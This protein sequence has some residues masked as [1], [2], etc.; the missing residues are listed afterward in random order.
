[1]KKIKKNIKPII[2]I[3]II[4]L[5]II[6][7]I[8]TPSIK[9]NNYIKGELKKIKKNTDITNIISLNKDNNYYIIKTTTDIIV[10]DLNYDEVTKVSI[11]TIKDNNLPITYRRGNLYYKEKIREKNKL[12]YNYYDLITGEYVYTSKVGGAHE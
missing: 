7:I 4:I 11:Q 6:T 1:M 10:L 3:F 8:L 12:T 2:I 5:I 9:N